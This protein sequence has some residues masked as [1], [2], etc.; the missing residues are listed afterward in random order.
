MKRCPA[1]FS[2]G[3]TSDIRKFLLAAHAS[4]I[5]RK[6]LKYQIKL[7]KH[8]PDARRRAHFKTVLRSFPLFYLGRYDQ[9]TIPTAFSDY[10]R[11]QQITR[12]SL[13][14]PILLGN[15]I[16]FNVYPLGRQWSRLGVW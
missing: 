3:R 14:Q 8:V 11:A 9:K 7:K 12:M 1:V 4:G 13:D 5:S 15:Y 10:A 6:I 2:E 16:Y